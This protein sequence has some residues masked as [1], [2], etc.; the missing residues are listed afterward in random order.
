MRP[1]NRDADR[2]DPRVERELEAVDAA[3]AGREVDDDLAALAEMSALASGE[4]PSIDAEFAAYLDERAAAGFP[5]PE[6]SAPRAGLLDRLR[7]VPPRR[8]IAPAAAAA[9]LLVVVGVAITAIGG[10]GGE[11]S[12]SSSLSSAP[13]ARPAGG[14]PAGGRVP[15]L[16]AKPRGAPAQSTLNVPRSGASAPGAG[17]L[18]D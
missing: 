13:S 17:G 1:R 16:A 11:G 18:E 8:L 15:G 6:R 14:G 7:A 5:R 10:F 12:S 9:T 4:R 3:L 2:L